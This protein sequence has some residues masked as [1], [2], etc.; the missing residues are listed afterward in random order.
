[1]NRIADSTIKGFLYQFNVTLEKI[2]ESSTE[3]ILVEGIVEDIDVV[4]DNFIEAIQCKYHESAESFSLSSISKPVLQ[5]LT[6]FSKKEIDIKYKLYTYFPGL[7]EGNQKFNQ[8]ALNTILRTKDRKLVNDYISKIITIDDHSICSLIE[9]RG[10]KT[11]EEKR[12]I[13]DYILLKDFNYDYKIDLSNF[14][15]NFEFYNGKNL[16]DLQIDI[17]EKLKTNIYNHS[18]EDIKSI[19]YPNAIQMIADISSRRG[20]DERIILK[21]GFLE[22]LSSIKN[23][24]LTRWTRELFTYE[25]ILKKIKKEL[26]SSLEKNNNK[27]MF[28]F[29]SYDFKNFDED[30]VIFLKKYCDKYI[31]KPKLSEPLILCILDYDK[32]DLDQLISRLY[33]KGISCTD[34]FAGSEFFGDSFLRNPLFDLDSGS[35]EFKI[36]ICNSSEE[37]IEALN[38]NKVDIAYV[39]T[40]D[41]Y[42]EFDLQDIETKYIEVREISDLEFILKLTER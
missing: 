30:I 34:G 21:E 26:H 28:V 38:Q 11:V 9:K 2:L 31:H 5:M 41:I 27:R 20:E 19:V 16:E 7:E 15:A 24:T 18:Y 14:I 25:E 4:S 32:G 36:R 12:Q 13:Y 3:E 42:V 29:N 10:N 33:K 35:M 39:T 40:N 17:S 22:S 1:M 8:D 23:I 6:T 37:Y